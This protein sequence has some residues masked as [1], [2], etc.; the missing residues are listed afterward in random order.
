M[1]DAGIVLFD[2]CT[3]KAIEA[4]DLLPRKIKVKDENESL[5]YYPKRQRIT[6]KSDMR[7][8]M[9]EECERAEKTIR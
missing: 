6:N 7:I 8:Y 4:I 3:S 2:V 1:P 9:S 5:K